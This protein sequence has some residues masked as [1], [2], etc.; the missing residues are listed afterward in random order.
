VSVVPLVNS[1]YGCPG[2]VAPP[3]E[4]DLLSV[5]MTNEDEH[6]I[7]CYSNV[8]S[9]ECLWG[10]VLNKDHPSARRKACSEVDF[11]HDVV[12]TPS[13]RTRSA[14]GPIGCLSVA[15]MCLYFFLPVLMI[16]TATPSMTIKNPMIAFTAFAPLRF[17]P[18]SR[19]AFLLLLQCVCFPAC[20]HKG[21]LP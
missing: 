1:F 19:A 12:L 2:P 7:W 20:Q 6:S 4:R 8:F 9:P 11:S 18:S 16:H 17:R 21:F 15:W 10:Y 13:A 3:F 14:H 5:L